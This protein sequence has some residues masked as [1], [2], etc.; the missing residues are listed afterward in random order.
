ML[1]SALITI[2]GCGSG[3]SSQRVLQQETPEAAVMRLSSSW[4][5]SSS[6][7][8]IEVDANKNFVRQATA[9]DGNSSDGDST[10]DS[11]NIITLTDFSGNSYDLVIIG[12]PERPENYDNIATITTHFV[13]ETGYLVIAFNLEFEEGQ[14][15]IENLTIKD[16]NGSTPEPGPDDYNISGYVKNSLNQFVSGATVQAFLIKS[17]EESELVG[18]AVTDEKGYYM[19]DLNETG[20]GDYLIV[21]TKDGLENQTKKVHLDEANQKPTQNCRI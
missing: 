15:W 5:N 17:E 9:D 10:S 6:A 19:I 1:L 12:E 2:V 18:S 7:P 16:N 4:R 20:A 8:T 11:S 14:W 13:Y 21:V 3:G